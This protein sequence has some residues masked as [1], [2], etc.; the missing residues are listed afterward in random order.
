MQP[1]RPSRYLAEISR[2]VPGIWQ[3]VDEI[4]SQRHRFGDDWPPWCFLPLGMAE[5]LFNPSGRYTS[6]QS[7]HW[8]YMASTRIS[9][10]A[11]WR[12]TQ[13]I[14]RFDSTVFEAVWETPLTGDLPVDLLFLLPEWC[15]YIETP[16]RESP[17]LPEPLHGFFAWL[18]HNAVTKQSE[19]FFVFDCESGLWPS[20]MPLARRSLFDICEEMRVVSWNA[21]GESVLQE[22]EELG[23]PEAFGMTKK[24]MAEISRSK[25]AASMVKMHS[26][27][28]S[29]LLYLC[30]SS[31]DIRSSK[32]HPFN[33]T[34]PTST[35]TKKG[36]RIFPPNH[37]TVWEVGWRIGPAL[38][39]ALAEEAR[40]ET[41]SGPVHSS[42]RPH[43]RR[44]HWHSYWTGPT[45]DPTRRSLELRW[46][47][48]ILVNAHSPDELV[49][50]VRGVE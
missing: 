29:L 32:G 50:T 44:A 13:G 46:L 42:P 6:L 38:R 4:R 9:T 25:G 19:L 39:R 17:L 26:P 28:I 40:T 5:K 31:R 20:P 21:H 45:S 24:Q 36:P 3:R 7:A 49:A 30:S 16:G 41:P 14:F 2:N 43:I 1:L 37:P 34:R 18:N 8:G 35:N 23:I 15:C 12:V 22:M 27:L 48:P 11:A 33:P 47:H 10:L